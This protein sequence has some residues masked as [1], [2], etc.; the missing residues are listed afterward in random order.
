MPGTV[1]DYIKIIQL[2]IGHSSIDMDAVT[3]EGFT[4][5]MYACL[6]STIEVVE[7]LLEAGANPN[8]QIKTSTTV[9][10]MMSGLPGDTLLQPQV[11]SFLLA[12]VSLLKQWSIYDMTALMFASMVGHLDVVQILLQAKAKPDIQ[13]ETGMTALLEAAMMGFSDIVQQLLECGA[14]PNISDRDGRIPLYAAVYYLSLQHIRKVTKDPTIS[15]ECETVDP[16]GSCEDYL[17]IMQL[18]IAQPNI[19]VNASFC[20]YTSLQIASR[21]GCTDAVELLL[22]VSADPNIQTHRIELASKLS[23]LPSNII[24]NP[25][26]KP[27][28]LLRHFQTV[29]GRTALMFASV[30]GHSEIIQ[31]LLNAKAKSDLQIENGETALYLAA[32]KGYPDIVQLLLEYGADPNISNRQG[33]TAIHAALSAITMT[34]K[35]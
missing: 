2:L 32:L 17:K 20:G 8:I 25:Q 31:L 6:Y 23:R 9:K 27:F 11:K 12:N 33:Q 34:T 22:Q 10:D 21:Y 13:N 18:L 35:Y 30:S 5:L 26:L 1:E 4:S 19:L 15:M 28:L 3:D 14:N 29:S 7:L 16:A 24:L